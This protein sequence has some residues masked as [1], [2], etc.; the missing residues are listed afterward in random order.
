M[1]PLPGLIP[2]AMQSSEVEFAAKLLAVELKSLTAISTFHSILISPS[3]FMFRMD[4]FGC[5]VLVVFE[6]T[7]RKQAL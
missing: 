6:S 3:L 1:S 7:E 5:V 4:G 2:T